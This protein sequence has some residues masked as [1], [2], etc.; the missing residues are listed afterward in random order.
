MRV[1]QFNYLFKN[2]Y[3]YTFFALTILITPYWCNQAQAQTDSLATQTK[4]RIKVTFEPP[5]EGK[6]QKTTGGATR[7][8]GQCLQDTE[9]VA[10]PLTP[11][12]PVTNQGLTVAAHPTLLFYLPETSA[13]KIFFS[14]HDDKSESYYQTVLPLNGKSGIISLTFPKKAPPLEIGKTYKW[15]LAVMCNNRLQPDSPMV[16]G[17]IKRVELESILGERL[18]NANT[19]ESA[20][21]YGK[22]GIWHETIMTLAQSIVAQPDNQDLAQT[23]EELLT[24]VGLKEVAQVPLIKSAPSK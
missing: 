24:S 23:W 3:L 21:L 11:L 6:S 13:Q 7:D 22:A 2:R 5:A 14:W 9:N 4:T 20:A 17:E 12:L 10:L 8:N 15:S 16:Q 19:L 1:N 18:K